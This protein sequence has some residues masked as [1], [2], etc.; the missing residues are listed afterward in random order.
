MKSEILADF[1]ICISVPLIISER[2]WLLP[3]SEIRNDDR[4]LNQSHAPMQDCLKM[5]VTGCSIYSKPK[6]IVIKL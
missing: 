1:Q 2:L 4:K 6:C 5:F 3:E